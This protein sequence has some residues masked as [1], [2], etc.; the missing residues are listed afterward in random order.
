[1]PLCTLMNQ[2]PQIK[3]V[4]MNYERNLRDYGLVSDPFPLN[5]LE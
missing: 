3:C 2:I 1:M 5:I 4:Y